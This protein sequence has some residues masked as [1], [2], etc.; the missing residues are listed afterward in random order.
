M[1]KVPGLGWLALAMAALATWLWL[2]V[3]KSAL[4]DAMKVAYLVKSLAFTLLWVALILRN[5]G[6]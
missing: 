2:G 1:N 4:P 5:R 3:D 6:Q